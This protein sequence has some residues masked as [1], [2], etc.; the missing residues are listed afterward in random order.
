M[1][2]TL[3]KKTVAE[4]ELEESGMPQKPQVM[5]LCFGCWNESIV[6]H[7][8]H[9]LF[10]QCSDRPLAFPQAATGDYGASPT[11]EGFPRRVFDPTDPR[12]AAKDRLRSAAPPEPSAASTPAA[13]AGFEPW[14]WTDY[15]GSGTF[16]TDQ[17][18]RV[19]EPASFAYDRD[20]NKVA[21][22]GGAERVGR[23]G[24]VL[25]RPRALPWRCFA[26]TAHSDTHT[27]RPVYTCP[28]LI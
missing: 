8:V 1:G 27:H 25:D 26:L 4:V 11:L 19:Q 2:R 15:P 3:V 10:V 22:G 24:Y 6:V 20:G 18:G 23:N 14:K 5:V 7:A 13:A 12:Q 9:S 21:V 28:V 16:G 17:E